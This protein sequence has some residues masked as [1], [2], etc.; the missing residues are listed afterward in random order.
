MII[1]TR[2]NFARMHFKRIPCE[3]DICKKFICQNDSLPKMLL[4]KKPLQKC[5][6]QETLA[7]VRLARNPC[8]SAPCKKPLQKCALQETLAKVRLA[9]SIFAECPCAYTTFIYTLNCINY[10]Q[11][12]YL[13][14]KNL[15]YQHLNPVFPILNKRLN[16]LCRSTELHIF[17]V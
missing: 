10:M 4:C 12:I 17:D 2:L 11:R 9:R 1:F 7:K 5:A 13:N 14:L 6:L 15:K 3:I 16:F 8:K